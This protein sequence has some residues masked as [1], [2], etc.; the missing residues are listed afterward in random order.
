MSVLSSLS[1]RLYENYVRRDGDTDNHNCYLCLQEIDENDETNPVVNHKGDGYLHPVHL[2]CARDAHKIYPHCSFCF[3]PVIEA[4]LYT[5]RENIDRAIYEI[6]LLLVKASPWILI[7]LCE[8]PYATL[9][10]K[11]FAADICQNSTVRSG[12]DEKVCLEQT[13]MVFS[14][15]LM[16]FGAGLII[17]IAK[18]IFVPVHLINQAP[19]E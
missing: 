13:T 2:D 12:Q 15:I 5:A 18:R 14:L 9:F 17:E 8:A 16:V 3:Q 1:A 10:V 4:S 6:Q 7:M 11:R 19:I